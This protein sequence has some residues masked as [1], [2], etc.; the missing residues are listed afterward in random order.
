[1]K[2]HTLKQILRFHSRQRSAG[3]ATN[4]RAGENVD[5]CEDDL[6]ALDVVLQLRAL[7]VTPL[8]VFALARQCKVLADKGI[9]RGVG[10]LQ[11]AT[12]EV[13]V[14]V[15]VTVSDVTD[16]AEDAQELARLV[17]SARESA[18]P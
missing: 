8:F 5:D 7:R 17:N 6:A 15:N 3:A 4:A 9:M 1:M 10:V 18:E 2:Q 14:G 12:R 16:A 11:Q 13:L